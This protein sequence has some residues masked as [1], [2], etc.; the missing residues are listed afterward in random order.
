[1]PLVE[2]NGVFVCKHDRTHRFVLKNG[3]MEKA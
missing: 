3:F 2:E 1:M